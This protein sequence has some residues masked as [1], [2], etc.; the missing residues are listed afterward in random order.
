MLPCVLLAGLLV[1][2]GWKVRYQS[3]RDHVMLQRVGKRDGRPPLC[4]PSSA[5]AKRQRLLGSHTASSPSQSHT[6]AQ[7]GFTCLKPSSCL[8]TRV[9][10]GCV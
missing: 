4:Q 2:L 3:F 8:H 7:G 6:R 5:K 1:L 9:A 10:L